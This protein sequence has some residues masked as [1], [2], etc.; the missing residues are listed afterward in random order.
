V[1]GRGELDVE[2]LEVVR[3]AQR[4]R[5]QHFERR[6]RAAVRVERAPRRGGRRRGVGGVVGGRAVAAAAVAV[7]GQLDELLGRAVAGRD[8]RALRVAAV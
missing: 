8:G 7:R 1:A 5:K 3:A 2:G 4:G 6:E